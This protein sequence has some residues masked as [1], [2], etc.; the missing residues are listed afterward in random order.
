MVEN[1]TFDIQEIIQESVQENIPNPT[2]V[3]DG[4]SKSNEN[5]EWL[6]LSVKN[7][8]GICGKL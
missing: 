4:K 2:E 6:C 3:E 8:N 5:Q 7:I 1:P